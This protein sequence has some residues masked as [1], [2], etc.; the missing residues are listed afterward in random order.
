M[1]L[2][3]LTKRYLGLGYSGQTEKHNQRII[4]CTQLQQTEEIRHDKTLAHTINVQTITDGISHRRR[5]TI[6][7]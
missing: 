4:N 1:M 2:T 7:V 5:V 6:H 3:Q